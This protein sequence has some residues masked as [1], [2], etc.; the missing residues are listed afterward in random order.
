MTLLIITWFSG[1]WRNIQ[2][3]YKYSR[4][5]QLEN[6]KVGDLSRNEFPSSPLCSS[7]RG[8]EAGIGRRT[9]PRGLF[10]GH[11]RNVR[12]TE[13]EVVWTSQ[14]ALPSL[15]LCRVHH[16]FQNVFDWRKRKIVDES[17]LWSAW[18]IW[19][20]VAAMGSAAKYGATANKSSSCLPQPLNM[21]IMS[22]TRLRK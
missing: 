19:R 20:D 4:V 2:S 12:P 5:L 7:F 14:H 11:N 22:C 15:W 6:G 1:R 13:P 18:L 16:R 10:P 21:R 8:R 3:T 17:V 9:Y